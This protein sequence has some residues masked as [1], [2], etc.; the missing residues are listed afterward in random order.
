VLWDTGAQV[1]I[2]PERVLRENFPNLL[3]KDIREL[4]ASGVKARG[5]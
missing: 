3:V 1:S 2:I 5:G 4:L